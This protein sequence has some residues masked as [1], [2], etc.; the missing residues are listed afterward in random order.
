MLFLD[1]TISRWQTLAC[2]SR[3]LLFFCRCYAWRKVAILLDSVLQ[4]ILNHWFY[5]I[6]SNKCGCGISV[7]HLWEKAKRVW[8]VLL[9]LL[10]HVYF[11]P[12]EIDWAFWCLWKRTPGTVT[13]AHKINH[14]SCSSTNTSND[15]QWNVQEDMGLRNTFSG[16]IRTCDGSDVRTKEEWWVCDNFS[17]STTDDA[18]VMCRENKCTHTHIYANTKTQH[19]YA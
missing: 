13:L 10:Y 1:M 19:I 2:R 12:P 18:W 17:V 3:L 16:I 6:L 5:Q 8:I 15:N 7:G 9:V 4:F 11:P 14:H